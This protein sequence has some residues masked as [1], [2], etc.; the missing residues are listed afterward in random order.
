MNDIQLTRLE[1]QI[2]ILL[3]SR[4]QLRA[5]NH[6]LRQKLAK[7]TQERADLLGKNQKASLKIK[8]IIAQLRND[9]P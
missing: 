8:R 7:V 9:I 6:S 3:K 2:E 1:S 4:D 5:E